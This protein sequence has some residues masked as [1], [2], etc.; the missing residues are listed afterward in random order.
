ML[1]K[2]SILLISI[3]FVALVILV[4]VEMTPQKVRSKN[5]HS[6]SASL[7]LASI[8]DDAVVPED[9]QWQGTTSQGKSISFYVADSGMT[10][11]AGYYEITY[12]CPSSGSHSWGHGTGGEFSIED[13]S[14]VWLYNVNPEG[15]IVPGSTFFGKIPGSFTSA[16]TCEGKLN[17]GMGAFTGTKLRTE[18]C[19]G[20]GITWKAKWVSPASASE[21]EEVMG[22]ESYNHRIE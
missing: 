21:I 16:T 15:G 14:F 22:R 4:V 8:Y 12:T 11:V 6:V 5:D 10:L 20:F 1:R 17:G 3:L 13:G 7:A 18:A 2:I 9:G 19:P